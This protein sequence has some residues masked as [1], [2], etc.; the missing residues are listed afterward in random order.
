MRLSVPAER[1]DRLW[2]QLDARRLALP[3][4]FHRHRT[5]QTMALGFQSR[6]QLQDA[7]RLR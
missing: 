1:L 6:D 3:T 7:G 5:T 2:P 4:G